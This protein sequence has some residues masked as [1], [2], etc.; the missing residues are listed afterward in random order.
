MVGTWP[1]APWFSFCTCSKENLLV[2]G[3]QFLQAD[4]MP[5]CHVTHNVKAQKGIV[6]RDQ[7]TVVHIQIL[8]KSVT[9]SFFPLGMEKNTYYW[10]LY[11]CKR[12]TQVCTK[13]A[14][15]VRRMLLVVTSLLLTVS[16]CRRW[17][18]KLFQATIISKTILEGIFLSYRRRKRFLVFVTFYFLT[19]FSERT[20]AICCRRSVCRLSVCRLSSVTFVRPTQAVQILRNISTALGALAIHWHPLKISWRSPQRNPSAGGVKHKRGSQ[21]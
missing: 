1:D 12:I 2:I 14:Y 8:L 17:L 18:N 6:L 3:A 4:G 7:L 20:F 11:S 9:E 13:F 10:R 5:F 19:F 15:S 21:V 16:V